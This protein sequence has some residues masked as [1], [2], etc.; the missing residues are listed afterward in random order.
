MDTEKHKISDGINTYRYEF[1]RDASE[2]GIKIKYPDGS[3]YWSSGSPS[4]AG[5]SI[6]SGWSDDYDSNRYVDGDTL[7]EVLLEKVPRKLNFSPGKLAVCLLLAGMGIFNML[8]PETAWYLEYGWRFKNAE[9][10][11]LALNVC[12]VSGGV[13]IVMAFI[14]FFS[15]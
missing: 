8:A 12:R 2:Y 15:I 5:T 10:S 14:V 13:I 7:V 4:Q 11:D 6:V 1:S 3:G 9:P